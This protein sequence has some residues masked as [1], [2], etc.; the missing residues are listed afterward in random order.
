[1]TQPELN[2]TV[3]ALNAAFEADPNAIHA[4]VCNRV[5]CNEALADD[6]FVVVEAPAPLNTGHRLTDAPQSLQM[7]RPHYQV[8]ALGLINAVLA[9]NGLP[10]IAVK[11]API[12]GSPGENSVVGFCEYKLPDNIK[13]PEPGT[14]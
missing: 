13:N 11:F 7:P 10:L 4:L 5:P 9:A 8:G 14:A 1:M 6:P 2:L 12:E 3:A